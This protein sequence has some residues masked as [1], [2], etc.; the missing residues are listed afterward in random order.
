MTDGYGPVYIYKYKTVAALNTEQKK[1][2]HKMDEQKSAVIS[3]EKLLHLII[4]R[5]DEVDGRNKKE[6]K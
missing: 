4:K 6:R 3:T 5:F 1:E 2:K